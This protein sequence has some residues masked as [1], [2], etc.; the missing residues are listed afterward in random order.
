MPEA[1]THR[2]RVRLAEP[3]CPIAPH[4]TTT[5][6]DGDVLVVDVAFDTAP[7]R[8]AEVRA[9]IEAALASGHCVCPDG[10]T[11]RWESLDGAP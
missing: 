10:D 3:P 9:L 8:E 11:S 2:A 1:Y 7:E 4:H 6:Y 5:S